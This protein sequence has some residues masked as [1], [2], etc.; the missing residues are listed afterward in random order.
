M[1]DIKPIDTR[2]GNEHRLIE[3]PVKA[4]QGVDCHMKC[5]PDNW[6]SPQHAV[7]S[8]IKHNEMSYL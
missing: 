5:F 3:C 4:Q 7:G 6:S 1:E 2:A 8:K